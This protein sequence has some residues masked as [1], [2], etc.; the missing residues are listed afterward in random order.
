MKLRCS[1]GGDYGDYCRILGCA[2]TNYSTIPGD[3]NLHND[4]S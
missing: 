1:D 4:G 3:S 2:A